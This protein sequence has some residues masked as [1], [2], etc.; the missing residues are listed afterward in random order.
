MSLIS[1]S[2]PIQCRRP[3]RQQDKTRKVAGYDDPSTLASTNMASNCTPNDDLC[4]R[5]TTSR[6]HTSPIHE[7][8]TPTPQDTA[9]DGMSAVRRSLERRGISQS[10]V[11]IIMSSMME[12]TDSVTVSILYYEMVHFL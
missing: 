1:M 8:K 4:T 6:L 3:L 10:A 12:K 5:A 7:Q 2:L 11:N 9:A